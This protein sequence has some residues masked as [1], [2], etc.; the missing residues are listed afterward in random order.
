MK[1]F[2]EN[3]GFLPNAF[4]RISLY[5]CEIPTTCKIR[6][7]FHNLHSNSMQQKEGHHLQTAAAYMFIAPRHVSTGN[8][9]NIK[10]HIQASDSIGAPRGR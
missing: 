5:V 6:S 7:I 1:L 4:G 2:F 10:K 9:V 3:L 8:H